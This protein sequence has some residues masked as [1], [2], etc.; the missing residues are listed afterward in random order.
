MLIT[1][2]SNR[3]L[4]RYVRLELPGND[5][6]LSLAEVEVYKGNTNIALKGEASQ[7]STAFGGEARFAIDGNKDGDFDKKSTT[8]TDNRTIHGGNSI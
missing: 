4:A 2:S 7:S 8:H 3:P 1:P 6:Y 5:K